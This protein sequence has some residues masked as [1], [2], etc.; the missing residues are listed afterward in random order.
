MSHAMLL[1]N[2]EPLKTQQSRTQVCL[3]LQSGTSGRITH[4]S[5]TLHSISDLFIP[6][7]YVHLHVGILVSILSTYLS[8]QRLISHAIPLFNMEKLKLLKT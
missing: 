3:Y 4:Y 6:A 8:M 7:S 2:L 5:Y 1:V